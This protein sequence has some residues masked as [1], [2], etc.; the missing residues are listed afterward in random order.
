MSQKS[1]LNRKRREEKQE[2][3]ARKVFKWIVISLLVL[4]VFI[5]AFYAYMLS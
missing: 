2:R 3:Q 5:T 4:A 1:K